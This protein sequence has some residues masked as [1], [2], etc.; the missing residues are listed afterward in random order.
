MDRKRYAKRT[1]ALLMG[2]VMMLA[3][4]SAVFALEGGMYH[5]FRDGEIS[6]YLPESWSSEEIS[7][8]ES[9]EKQ[10][11]KL[12]EAWDDT[13]ESGLHL[14]MYIMAEEVLRNDYVYFDDDEDAALEY[15]E[16]YGST[17]LDELYFERLDSEAGSGIL[18]S[19]WG[20]EW[21][22][23]FDGQLNG[24]LVTEMKGNVQYEAMPPEDLEHTIY[25]TAKMTDDSE[26][27]VH[28]ILVFHNDDDTA[29]TEQQ[30]QL[31]QEI[32]DEFYDYGYGD[33]MT[34]AKPDDSMWGAGLGMSSGDEM[35]VIMTLLI[36]IVSILAPLGII[37]G[38]IVIIAK[39]A[40]G[41]TGQK[42][43]R[44]STVQ[45]RTRE[46]ESAEKRYF[47]SLQTLHKAG[48]LTKEELRDMLERHE[49]SRARQRKI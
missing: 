17:A 34:G 24:F 45:M 39:R 35:D 15:Y 43:E 48:L 38:V 8:A 21:P 3:S 10:Y 5:D 42:A 12:L 19:T 7:T 23:F 9:R 27:V 33:R 29:L 41:R 18:T 30:A 11:E 14:D 31:A 2:I 20:A 16:D 25:L 44:R 4:G 26:L 28:N 22:V 46:A 13:G 37:V 32:A 1:V 6:L 47:E 49:R 40:A 36:G